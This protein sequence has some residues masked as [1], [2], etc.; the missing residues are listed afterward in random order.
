MLQTVASDGVNYD[1]AQDYPLPRSGH[2][3]VADESNL[4]V[5]GGFVQYET[6]LE[7]EGEIW[8]YNLISGSWRK[9]HFHNL[10]FTL[11]ASHAV[12]AIGHTVII[13]GGTGTQF[14][15]AI[16]NSLTVINLNTLDSYLLPVSCKDGIRHHMPLPTY[17]HTLTHVVLGDESFLYKVG[18]VRS[19]TYTMNVYRY[20]LS[21][22]TWERVS[23]E[24]DSNLWRPAPRY[25]HDTV[26]F[27]QKLHIVAGG[28]AEVTHPLWPM[29]VLDPKTHTWSRL[30]FRGTRPPL[31][32][33][34]NSVLV[35]HCIYVFGGLDDD[36]VINGDIFRLDLSTLSCST[37][38]TQSS[39]AYFH[40]SAF[41]PHARE[42]YVFGGN[43]STGPVSRTNQLNRLRLS[44]RPVHLLEM[45]WAR[46]VTRMAQNNWFVAAIRDALWSAD[47]PNV[48]SKSDATRIIV[49][50]LAEIRSSVMLHYR[51]PVPPLLGCFRP[52][53]LSLLPFQSTMCHMIQAMLKAVALALL[54]KYGQALGLHREACV[55]T[56]ESLQAALTEMTSEYTSSIDK[57]VECFN[58][59][60]EFPDDGDEDHFDMMKEH[61]TA[62]SLIEFGR[63]LCERLR[64]EPEDV[65]PSVAFCQAPLPLHNVMD[66][67]LL[68]LFLYHLHI[69]SRF[70]LRLPEGRSYLSYAQLLDSMIS[71]HSVSQPA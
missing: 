27:N 33:Y 30:E 50:I 66:G 21:C 28:N 19:T 38:G 67:F 43:I 12:C 57:L 25:R 10:N 53:C 26:L 54:T 37:V 3:V 40:S 7:V 51:C 18:G 56:V 48:W 36:D 22:K 49:G 65:P 20:S 39:P 71:K 46:F 47:L 31:L 16:D 41:V 62:V 59:F 2:C 4:Y 70:L 1:S 15:Q 42:I 69:P 23:H 58:Y 63:D 14:G 35:E 13:H 9:L 68:V 60:G 17:G 24:Q 11:A 8:R 45:A 6:Y 52:S 29:P 64:R 5:I 44:D 61:P 34:Q 32:R 55:T